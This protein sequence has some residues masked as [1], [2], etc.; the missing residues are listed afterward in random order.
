MIDRAV[1]A[2]RRTRRAEAAERAQARIAGEA[3]KAVEVL[4][5]RGAELER[6]VAELGEERAALAAR[7]AGTP[8]GAPAVPDAS[9]MPRRRSAPACAPS[10]T[11]RRSRRPWPKP[12]ACASSRA[13]G[14]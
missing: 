12:R 4:E 1:L 11:A 13:S 5:A 2:E 8:A 9:S 3:L 7:L 10:A 14:G 6:R